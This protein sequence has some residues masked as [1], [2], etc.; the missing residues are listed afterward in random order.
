MYNR[1]I[2]NIQKIVENNIVNLVSRSNL[3]ILAVNYIIF[4]V[5]SQYADIIL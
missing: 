5:C 4:F 2:M 3:D 1:N